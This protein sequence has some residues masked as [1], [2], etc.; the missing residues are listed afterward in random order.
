MP[1]D[2]DM[3]MVC[4]VTDLDDDNDGFNDDVD[5]FPMNSSEAI[6]TDGDGIG[7]NADTDDDND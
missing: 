5:A 1:A 2:Y 4:D 3:D 6:D 7:D